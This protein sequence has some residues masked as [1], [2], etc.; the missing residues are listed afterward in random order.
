L[1]AKCLIEVSFP[2]GNAAEAALRALSH[3][4]DVG[5]RSK[6]GMETEGGRLRLSIEAE[7]V[8]ALRA[9]ANAF[10]RGLQAFEGL[11]A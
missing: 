8:V 3:E 4:K 7:D 11:E 9:A 10:M 2:D 1:K 6:A 5:G